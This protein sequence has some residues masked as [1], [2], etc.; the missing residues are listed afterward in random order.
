M[1]DN[2]I[3]GYNFPPTSIK[4]TSII[5]HPIFFLLILS[6]SSSDI[7][8]QKKGSQYIYLCV[9]KCFCDNI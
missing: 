5:N 8:L 4:T 9:K 1:N 2:L 6:A 7:L 3:N